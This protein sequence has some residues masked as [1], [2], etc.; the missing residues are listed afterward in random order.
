[1]LKNFYCKR[2]QNG[3]ALNFVQFLLDHSA[4]L[5]AIAVSF[6]PFMS[7]QAYAAFTRANMKCIL[8]ATS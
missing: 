5:C 2:L 6:P 8:R 4:L 7:F 3:G 1:M